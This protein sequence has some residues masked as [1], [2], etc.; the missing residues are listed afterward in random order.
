MACPL[1]Y[2]LSVTGDCTNT[3]SGA[4]SLEI[5]GSAPDYTIQW[6]SPASL[7]TVVLGVGVTGYTLT[8]LSAS[9]YSFTIIDSCSPTN[10]VIP[11]NV[12][13]SSGTCVSILGFENTLCGEDNGSVSAMTSNFYGQS[14][15]YLYET[16]YGYITSATTTYDNYQFT[17]LSGGTYYVVANDGGGCTGQSESIIVQDSATVDY[18]FYVVNDAGC[19]VNSGK[20][21]ITG[22]TGNPPYTYLWFDGS[23]GSTVTGLTEGSYNVTVTDNTGCSVS[24]T[25]LVAKV[26]PL[27][28]ASILTTDPTCGASDGEI[29][30][31]VTGGTSPYNF[32]ASTIGNYFTFDSDY[33]FT[34][35]SS[36]NYD[37]L[38][39]DSGLCTSSGSA[40][41]LTPGGFSV[42]SFSYSPLVCGASGF[43]NIT[44]NGGSP[45]YV[46]TLS[47]TGG[48]ITNQTTSSASWSFTNLLFGEYTLTISDNGP[49][50]YSNTF[51]I[52]N[53]NTFILT[54]NITG[55]TCGISNGSIEVNV[56]GGSPSYT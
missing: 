25:T 39:T 30:V 12:Y 17:N 47:K 41:L 54:T 42:V 44:L 9:T 31:V 21:F 20:I 19:A 34:N 37:I 6:L 38:I 27:G 32:S 10:T 22:L 36:G 15:F 29:T 48:P 53:D 50:E 55:T 49:C 2:N 24:K 3:N 43:V 51:T 35:V 56:S 1:S 11:V 13:I 18:G 26:P 45:P 14:S 8:N 33:T 52:E 5:L 16:T 4:F 28:I 23:T 7:G 46:Y 40:T